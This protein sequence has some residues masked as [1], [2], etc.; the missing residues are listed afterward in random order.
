VRIE[1]NECQRA[2]SKRCFPR[3]SKT[4]SDRAAI[5]SKPSRLTELERANL[6][7]YLDGELDADTSHA[8]EAKLARDPASRT[9]VEHLRRT[10]DLLDFLPKPEPSP[11]FTNRTLERL[12][13]I[14][15]PR[16]LRRPLPRWVFGAGWAAAVAVA[17]LGS[18]L[19][20]TLLLAL[21]HGNR[22]PTEKDLVRDLRV[23][24][25]KRV[26]DMIE[27]VDFLRELDQPDLFG[28]DAHGS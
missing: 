24:E 2:D 16:S 9:E 15:Q 14:R 1:V 12:K 22:E 11:N 19:A 5:M 3:K 10:W 23:I 28:D 18:Y 25:N 13:P 21:V 7:A 6:V 17:L 4:M 20:M 27:D 26:Y 8:L